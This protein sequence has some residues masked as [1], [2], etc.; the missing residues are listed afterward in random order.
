MASDKPMVAV[1]KTHKGEENMEIITGQI[2]SKDDHVEDKSAAQI[3]IIEPSQFGEFDE[4]KQKWSM[5]G[6]LKRFE[7]RIEKH[8]T[9]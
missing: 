1:M 6:L 7:E 9:E 5:D 2:L 4:L 8:C 3:P